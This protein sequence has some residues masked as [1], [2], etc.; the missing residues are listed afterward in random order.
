MPYK[1]IGTQTEASMLELFHTFSRR[2]WALS[3]A[4][5]YM[6]IHPS[7][8]EGDIVL[9]SSDD[10]GFKFF[11]GKLGEHSSFFRDL[12]DLP[13]SEDSSNVI[14]LP[15]ASAATIEILLT[16]ID[17]SS[18]RARRYVPS[19]EVLDELVDVVD[20]FDFDMAKVQFAVLDSNLNVGVRYA[21]ACTYAPGR[22]RDLEAQC[23]ATGSLGDCDTWKRHPQARMELARL[24]YAWS[25]IRSVYKDTFVRTEV[26]G[27]D[28]FRKGCRKAECGAYIRCR[29]D[30]DVLKRTA[31]NAA[32]KNISQTPEEGADAVE[33]ACDAAILCDVCAERLCKHAKDIWSNLVLNGK[34]KDQ[35]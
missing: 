25:R 7:F 5:Q 1:T 29:G 10:V 22:K 9:K 31:A 23:F 13:R 20:A 30:W 16:E 11:L 4:E 19:V 21:F 14:P 2:K 26:Y 27:G 24:F 3:L 33:E 6:N 8:R 32:V 34:W 28:D 17:R 12:A 35:P 18:S 15:N